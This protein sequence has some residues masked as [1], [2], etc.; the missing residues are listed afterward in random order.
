MRD[1]CQERDENDFMFDV[2]E[3]LSAVWNRYG[4]QDRPYLDT[5]QLADTYR[6]SELRYKEIYAKQEQEPG[7]PTWDTILLEETFEALSASDVTSRY[8]ELVQVAAMACLAAVSEK[9][10][11]RDSK[12]PYRNGVT[13]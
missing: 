1:G 5:P 11:I 6:D 10:R 2:W 4:R 9:R 7:G 3:E 12:E 8:S 13:L